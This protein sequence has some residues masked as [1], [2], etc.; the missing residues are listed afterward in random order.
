MLPF[1]PSSLPDLTGK[2]FIVTGGNT[3]IGYQTVLPLLLK[4][5]TVY[6]GSRSPTKAS[7]AIS[8]LRA[9]LPS[10]S[11]AQIHPL[12]IDHM[13]LS[14]VRTA[15]LSFL[16]KETSLLGLVNNA[17]IMAVPREISQDGYES[18]W[19][20]NY[21]SHW[22][23]TYLLLPLLL[24]TAKEEEENG[25]KG[26]VRIVNVTS[27]G[28]TYFPPKI[29]IDFEDINQEKGGPWSRYGMSKLA[30]ILH[31]KSLNRLYGPHST[32]QTE[33]ERGQIWTAAV[34][35]GN[36]PTQLS[37]NAIFLGDRLN[38]VAQKLL[39]CMGAWVPVEKCAYGS[40]MAV[41]GTEFNADMSGGYLVPGPKVGKPSKN[42][43]NKEM[44]EKLWRWTEEELRG[45]GFIE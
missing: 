38:K 20:T 22:L 43:E 39:G 13:S 28:H 5:S 35:P 16:T 3:G 14:S 11:T 8:S 40:L 15:A 26:V 10:T 2:V 17:G 7:T 29:G 32:T 19:Q 27:V 33:E 23:L 44:A 21:L 9:L 18:Q 30:N 31:T 34:H 24:K 36:A 12:I 45:K 42:A 41:A 37:T 1:N 4:N 6:L 25:K